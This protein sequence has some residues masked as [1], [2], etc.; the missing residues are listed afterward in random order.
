MSS[1][2]EDGKLIDPRLTTRELA[3]LWG[4]SPGT[5]RNWR[6]NKTGPKSFRV[7]RSVRY[8]TSVVMA[9]ERAGKIK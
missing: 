2:N 4:L 3:K 1:T 6:A 9:Y 8:K 5:L 7:G